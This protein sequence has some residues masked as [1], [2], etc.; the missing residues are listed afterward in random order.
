LTPQTWN[1]VGLDS[2]DVNTGPNLFPVGAKVC[3]GTEGS[4]V[5]VYFAW[6]SSNSYIDLRPGSKGYNNTPLNITF[7]PGD[8]GCAD[9]FF[10]AEVQRNAA[11]FDTSREYKI[12]IGADSTPTP[13]ALYVE[14]LISQSRNGITDVKVNGASIPSGGAMNLVVGNTYTI[15]LIGGTA[16]QGYNQFS[17]FFSLSNT[18]FQILSVSSVY[19]ANNSPYVPDPVFGT[20][21]YAD[22][23]KWDTDPNSL[24]YRS[25]IGGDYKAGGAPVTTTYQ[26]KIIGGGGTAVTLGS[27]LYDFSG[28]S[29]H[30]NGDYATS[31]R[32]ATIIDP[33]SVTI[34]K[35]FSPNPTNVATDSSLTVT[36]TNPNAGAVSGI[37]F[38]D[39]FPTTPGTGM[40]LKNTTSVN[41]CG[42]TLTDNTGAPLAVNS[43]GI[44]LAGGTVPASG[45]CVVQVNIDT[46]ATG[47]YVNTTQNLFI[48]TIDTGKTA[49]ETLVVGTTAPLAPPPSSCANPVVI[50]RWEMNS[51]AV[52]PPGNGPLV[53]AKAGDVAAAAANYLAPTGVSTVGIIDTHTNAWGLAVDSV[54]GNAGW[55]E[56]PVAP[57]Y[58]MNNYL[59][60][61]VDTSNYG[62]VGVSFDAGLFTSGLWGNPT[63]PIFLTST[64]NGTTNLYATSPASIG[65]NA[66]WVTGL[67]AAN[68]NTD[69]SGTTSFRFGTNGAN[70][71]NAQF[72]LD[73]IVFTGCP[74]TKPPVIAKK[75]AP[76]PILAGN[77]ST[78]TFVITNP[79]PAIPLAGVNF[80]DAD[81]GSFPATMKV[82]TPPNASTSGCGAPTFGPAA[83]DT[84][85][86]FT[87]GSIAAGGTCIVKVDVTAT[88]TGVNT[89][90]AVGA[91]GTVGGNKATD[92]LTVSPPHPAITL[93]KEVATALTAPDPGSPLWHGDI[94][95]K[96]GD[97]VFYQFT[98]QNDGDVPLSEVLV[99]DAAFP[100]LWSCNGSGWKYGDGT[101]TVPLSSG[102]FTLEVASNSDLVYK[103]FATCIIGPFSAATGSQTNNAAADSV[104]SGT[105]Y[106]DTDSATY[107]GFTPP[108]VGKSFSP[109]T[110]ASGGTATMTI[111]V[112]NPAANPGNLAGVSIGDSYSGTLANNAA[113]SVTCS[114]AG[115]ATLTGGANSGTAVGFSAGTIVPGGSC[116]ITQSVTATSTTTNTTAAPAST[117]IVIAGKS[118]P[119]ALTGTVASATLTVGS[120]LPSLTVVK[121]VQAVS[122][123]VNGTTT[124]KPIPGAVMQYTI[125]VMNSGPGVVDNNSTVITDVI[126]ADTVMCVTNTCSNPPVARTFCSAAPACGLT[127]TFPADVTFSNQV[128]GGTPYTYTPVPDADGYDANVTGL[129]I[130]PQGILNAAA[131]ANPADFRVTFKAKIK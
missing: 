95:V 66:G 104:Y 43:P 112:T 36:I 124:P 110:I 86:S 33:A 32:I 3:G 126:P 13:R 80:V 96:T 109:A 4:S 79:N 120:A 78:L 83:N 47:S 19:S 11:A 90:G 7:R 49:S 111:T 58:A 127:I 62:G 45:S 125:Q 64:A 28:S 48:G 51:T 21:L 63:S 82:A 22:A 37:G 56:N 9:A 122:D 41:T 31:A 8:G 113:G 55:S 97:T 2:N 46:T 91:T 68:M 131:G 99:T 18:I 25:C 117:G 129:R 26:I 16:T 59:E 106:P 118:A 119:L 57:N 69:L 44:K 100:N 70:K 105:H 89:T 94:A 65:K 14:R 93:Y 52:G 67:T 101:T 72:A 24:T 114:G 85:L 35:S 12:Y 84:S 54:A 88:A 40:K 71:G 10:E 87:N 115:S 53:T 34:S 6:L 128:G 61:S 29:Y 73:N 121:S 103:D 20:G 23:C 17:S 102:K 98:V 5:D 92:T 130:N 1:T 50:A 75:F 38:T 15:D 76:N 108:T 77:K 74:R 81:T 60:F 116:T 27:L 107:Y 39:I 123:P 42:G 30:Y